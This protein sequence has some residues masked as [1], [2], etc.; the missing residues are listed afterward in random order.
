MEGTSRLRDHSGKGERWC[1]ARDSLAVHRFS[2]YGYLLGIGGHILDEIACLG[3]KLYLTI[4]LN[5]GVFDNW[6]R[7]ASAFDRRKYDNG[8]TSI[9]AYWKTLVTGN[10]FPGKEIN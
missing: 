1:A 3:D 2:D 10:F 7:L 5:P 8:E 9:D 6:E 4:L